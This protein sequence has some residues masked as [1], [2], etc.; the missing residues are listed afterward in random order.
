MSTTFTILS[1]YINKHAP[2][3]DAHAY[4]SDYILGKELTQQPIYVARRGTEL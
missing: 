2:V 3:Y 1:A 4:A